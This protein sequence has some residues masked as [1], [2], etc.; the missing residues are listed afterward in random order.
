MNDVW[1]LKPIPHRIFYFWDSVED[2]YVILNGCRKKSRKAPQA[3]ILKA[4]HLR[5]EYFTLQGGIDA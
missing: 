2:S 1:Q 3:E 4:E 5:A